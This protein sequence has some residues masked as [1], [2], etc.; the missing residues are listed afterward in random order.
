MDPQVIY[1]RVQTAVIAVLA[2][3]LTNERNRPTQ[4]SQIDTGL[5]FTDNSPDGYG[6]SR[7]TYF[8][9]CIRI[10][11]ELQKHYPKLRID[12]LF[13]RRFEDKSLD[14]FIEGVFRLIHPSPLQ[15]IARPF[16]RTGWRLNRIWN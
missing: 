11:R 2:W 1:D 12:D 4:T 13:A 15:L 14:A 3:H 6:C 8:T 10:E 5:T 16:V 7:Q 9:L